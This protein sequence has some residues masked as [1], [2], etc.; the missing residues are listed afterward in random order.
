MRVVFIAS[1]MTTLLVAQEAPKRPWTNVS[2]F[3]LVATSGNAKGQTLGF[4]ND[5]AYKWDLTTL[6]V[7]ASAVRANSTVTNRTA[8]GTTLNNAV[9][10]EQDVTTTTAE[11]YSLN[12]RVDHRFKSY[13]RLYTFGEAGWVRNRPAGLDSKTGVLGGVGYIW[14]DSPTTKFRTDLG[15]GVTHEVPMVEP[16]GFKATYGTWTLGAQLK[17]ALGATSAYTMD[18]ALT[19]SFSNSKDWQGFIKQGVTATLSSRLALKVGLDLFYRN[20]PNLIAVNAYTPA[21]PPVLL[22]QVSIP[23]K[24]LDSVFTTSLVVTF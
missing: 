16:P 23:A 4:A 8:V 12:G 6:T 9:V 11:M 15:F 7:K 14:A 24:K 18:L 19:D 10:S 20:I 17:Q 1:L 21:I 13:D 5:F 22:G 3:S 2:T